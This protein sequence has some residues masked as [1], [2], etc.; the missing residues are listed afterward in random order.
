MMLMIAMLVACVGDVAADK[1]VAEVAEPPPAAEK[2]VEAPAP[3]GAEWQV[4]KESSKISAL[5]AK[6]SATHPIDFPDFSGTLTMG[7]A[8]PTA[9]GFEVTME[10]L[11][12]DHPKLTTHLKDADFFDVP[13]HPKSTFKSSAVT[14]GSDVEGATHTVEG[15][16]TIRGKTKRITF[17]ATF[18]NGDGSAEA[19]AEFAIDRRDFDVVYPGRKDDLVQD[20]VVL[21]IALKASRPGA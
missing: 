7:K 10:T 4:D 13:N 6:V 5:G 19:K 15:D 21:N 17:P 1:V 3:A 18:T 20:K 11:V 12:A 14:A 2:K 8:G 9:V 16:L